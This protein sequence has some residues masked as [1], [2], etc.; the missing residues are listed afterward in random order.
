M[1]ASK[2]TPGNRIRCWP[3]FPISIS[4]GFIRCRSLLV[5]TSREAV[6]AA[7]KVRHGGYLVLN[8][9][10]HLDPYLGAYRVHRA[11]VEFAIARDWPFAWFG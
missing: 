10:A 6:A 9:F 11:V 3:A 2:S 8:D 4:I 7:P 5:G 1:P